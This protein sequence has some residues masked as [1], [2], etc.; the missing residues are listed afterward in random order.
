MITLCFNEIFPDYATFKE[1]TK[2]FNLYETTDVLAE[3][4]N[5][6]LYYL[7]YNRY[8]G[9]SLAY[10]TE[11]EFTAEFGIAYMEYF[12]QFYARQKV[13]TDIYKLTD[14]DYLIMGE[15]LNN[16]SSNP[17]YT[18]TDPFEYIKFTTNQSRGR[19]KNN[20]LVAFIN[21]LRSQPDAQLNNVINKFDYLWLDL[22]DT[23]NIY[24]YNKKGENK[25]V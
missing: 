15:S 17:N 23:E 2:Q 1:F 10:D 9:C 7:L 16:Y 5:T 24:L 18:Q 22:L 13:L 3:T 6:K 25:D 11:E 19:T 12:M 8:I 4:I 14:E 21:A 20:K